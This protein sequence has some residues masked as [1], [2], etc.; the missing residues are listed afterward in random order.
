M[1]T[2]DIPMLLI[3]IWTN[4]LFGYFA[5]GIVLTVLDHWRNR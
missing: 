3:V 2:D 4:F 1:S 5:P